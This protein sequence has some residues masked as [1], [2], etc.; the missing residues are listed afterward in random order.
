MT[1]AASQDTRPIFVV[2]MGFDHYDRMRAGLG[3]EAAADLIQSVIARLAAENAD[4]SVVRASE[5]VISAAFQA[6]DLEHAESWVIAAL[7]TAQGSYK[8]GEHVIDVRLRAGLSAGGPPAALVRE[9]D[10]ALDSARVAKASLRLFD[11]AAHA[12]AADAL[13][14]MPELRIAIARGQLTLA[15]QPKHDLRTGALSGVECLVR[16]NHPERGAIPPALFIPLAEETGDIAALTRWVVDRALIEQGWLANDGHRLAFAVNLSGRLL[17]D[18]DFIGWIVERASHSSGKLQLEITET[19]VIDNPEQAFQN[20]RRLARAGLGCSIDD[21]GSGLSSLAYLKRIEAT[22]LKLDKSLVD[23]VTRSSRDLM[24]I[25]STVDL[26][27]SLGMKVVAEG[28]EDAETAAL[29]ASTGCDMG[30]GYYFHRPMTL[31][32]LG[33]LLGR[34]Q[35][36]AL[37][38]AEC[39]AEP[40][41]G[42]PTDAGGDVEQ[43]PEARQV[44][45][46]LMIRP[47]STAG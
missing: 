29:L 3:Y 12:A 19:A 7:G 27:H 4:W 9:A 35:P 41:A 20:V 43:P 18:G 13:A 22:E 5:D 36:D 14:L 38:P 25:R 2:A 30:Q 24:V 39:S 23:D 26:A 8:V 37:S 10:I 17:G 32:D 42:E 44:T 28:I 45:T 15:H 21:Y 34:R 46:A 6:A 11:P 31:S 47:Q 33:A 1:K 40:A 16:W